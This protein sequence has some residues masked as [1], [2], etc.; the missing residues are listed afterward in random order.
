ML[1][2]IVLFFGVSLSSLS[3]AE[4]VVLTNGKQIKG[5]IIEKSE[6]NLKI[7]A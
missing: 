4:T 5:E 7:E 2:I 6:I 3:Y 1:F